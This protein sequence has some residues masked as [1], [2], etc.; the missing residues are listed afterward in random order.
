[1]TREIQGWISVPS[2]TYPCPRQW[3]DAQGENTAF[4]LSFSSELLGQLGAGYLASQAPPLH[5]GKGLTIS[6]FWCC[7]KGNQNDKEL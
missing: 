3:Q 4:I 6:N 2:G 5:L 7:G 1:M